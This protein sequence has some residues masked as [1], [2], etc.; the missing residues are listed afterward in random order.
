MRVN[1]KNR[2]NKFSN[3][4]KKGYFSHQCEEVIFEKPNYKDPDTGDF[5]DPYYDSGEGALQEVGESMSTVNWDED[6]LSWVLLGAGY[7]FLSLIGAFVFPP[8]LICLWITNGDLNT[9]TFG[10]WGNGY[11]HD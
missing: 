8:E 6:V 2:G 1:L 5:K 9:C 4:A 10:I 7:I 3:L 11:A